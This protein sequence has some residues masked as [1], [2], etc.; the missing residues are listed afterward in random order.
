MM[1]EEQQA[2]IDTCHHM[3]SRESS[4]EYSGNLREVARI[5]LAALTQPASPALKLPETISVRTAIAALD[6]AS[7]VTTM[8]QSYKMAWNACIAEVKRLN[9]PH[10]AHIEPSCATGGAWVKCSE[11]MP[12]ELSDVHISEVE[13]IVTD[14]TQVGT[15]ECRRGYMPRPWV[16]WSNYGDIDAE[17]ITHWMPLPAEPEA[18]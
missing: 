16:E 11:R 13:V 9:A 7:E 3:I 4:S 10:T 8:A 5:A 18:E 2:L 17:K 6:N 1:T 12:L 15:C 14:G